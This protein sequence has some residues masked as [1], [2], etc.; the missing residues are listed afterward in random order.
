MNK[1]FILWCFT[2]SAYRVRGVGLGRL[3]EAIRRWASRYV[4][5]EPLLI[6]DFFCSVKFWCYL[7]EHISSQIFFQGAYS[8]NQLDLLEQILLQDGAFVDIG[9]N[10]GDFTVAAAAL[11]PEGKVLAFEPVVKNLDRLRAIVEINRFS[12]VHIFPVALGDR[13]G[14]VEMYDSS[15]EFD[16]GKINSG[17]ASV[18]QSG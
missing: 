9:A 14:E 6:Q 2:R 13:N 17:L 12:N 7:Q 10:Q 8:G 3:C 16:D 11:M 4:P 15:G 18:F 5:S 1:F